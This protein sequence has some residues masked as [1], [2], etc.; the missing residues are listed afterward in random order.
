MRPGGVG[1]AIAGFVRRPKAPPCRPRRLPCQERLCPPAAP[2][3]AQRRPQRAQKG[4]LGHAVL[5]A[6]PRQAAGAASLLHHRTS[7]QGLRQAAGLAEASDATEAVGTVGLGA[8]AHVVGG[9]HVGAALEQQPHGVRVLVPDS[10]HQRRRTPLP[11]LAPAK[12]TTQQWAAALPHTASPFNGAFV[13]ATELLQLAIATRNARQCQPTEER[14][15]LRANGIM[16][17]C[18]PP[19]QR[20]PTKMSS[21]SLARLRRSAARPQPHPLHTRRPTR[22]FPVH[23]RSWCQQPRPG[24]SA[25]PRECLPQVWLLAV[26][27]ARSLGSMF[28]TPAYISALAIGGS[29]PRDAAAAQRSASLPSG[30]GHSGVGGGSRACALGVRH[31]QIAAENA[32]QQCCG[33]GQ[34]PAA[35]LGAPVA[36]HS[37]QP[38]QFMRP[39]PKR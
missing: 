28:V 29:F 6:M 26:G 20:S 38:P 8:R 25:V 23:P 3:A 39:S 24:H 12:R 30:Q 17:A 10:Q 4:R 35:A 22:L 34:D 9:V 11:G 27:A 19:G 1:G 15:E 14:R 32:H 33:R 13:P 7:L 37:R 31:A 16:C 18:A 2:P 36:T 21:S 5:L